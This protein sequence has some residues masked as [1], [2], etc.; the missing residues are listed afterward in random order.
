MSRAIV[1]S[2][3]IRAVKGGPDGTQPDGTSARQEQAP[4]LHRSAGHPAGSHAHGCECSRHH[5]DRP[6]RRRGSA[7]PGQARAAVLPPGARPGRPG[8]PLEE[9]RRR[10]EEAEHPAG[11]R[12]TRHR[13]RQR[14]RQDALGRRAHHQLVASVPPAAGALRA[15]RGHSRGLPHAGLRLD[16]LQVRGEGVLIGA[17]K[18]VSLATL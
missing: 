17:L 8:V 9:A 14:A 11:S 12:A 18:L 15:A 1:D 10:V 3:S 6:A 7:P 16:L 2:S 13:A 5:P 4:R